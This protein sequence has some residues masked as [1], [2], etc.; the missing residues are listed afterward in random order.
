MWKVAP[1]I[2]LSEPNLA[3]EPM[4]VPVDTKQIGKIMVK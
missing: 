2:I 1:L 4:S 3:E